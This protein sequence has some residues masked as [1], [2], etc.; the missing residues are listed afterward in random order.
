MCHCPWPMKIPRPPNVHYSAAFPGNL[1]STKTPITP[2]SLNRSVFSQPKLKYADEMLP[3]TKELPRHLGICNGS[4]AEFYI[5]EIHAQPEKGFYLSFSHLAD[6]NCVEL[7]L[8]PQVGAFASQS[9]GSQ[10]SF[11]TDD[12]VIESQGSHKGLSHQRIEGQAMFDN[13]HGIYKRL[14]V[15][16]IGDILAVFEQKMPIHERLSAEGDRRIGFRMTKSGKYKLFICGNQFRLPGCPK[17]EATITFDGED[18]TRLKCF[19][20]CALKSCILKNMAALSKSMSSGKPMSNK[21]TKG[22]QPK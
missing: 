15:D 21:R 9:N 1:S 7:H 6:E 3:T 17:I 18:V 2:R 10:E 14:S 8:K 19:F 5:L 11:K 20:E 13:R 12:Y 16:A 4:K 22:K